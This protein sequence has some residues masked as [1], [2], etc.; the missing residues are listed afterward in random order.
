[1]RLVLSVGIGGTTSSFASSPPLE[2]FTTE[3]PLIVVLFVSYYPFL[4]AG[5]YEEVRGP[6]SEVENIDFILDINPPPPLPLA[7][8]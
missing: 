7:Y 3:A 4:S 8:A 6:L 1:M 5:A 2:T